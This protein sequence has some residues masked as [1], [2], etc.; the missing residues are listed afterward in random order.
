MPYFM[1]FFIVVAVELQMIT[2]RTRIATN[3]QT[4]SEKV[5][6][7]T[8]GERN[9]I[10]ENQSTSPESPSIQLMLGSLCYFSD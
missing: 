9:Q 2:L 10:R 5:A 1:K 6:L 8:T 7:F 4:E 3:F